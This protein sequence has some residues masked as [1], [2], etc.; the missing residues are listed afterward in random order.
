MLF[1]SA[2]PSS[3]LLVTAELK[4]EDA[5]ALAISEAQASASC[6][7]KAASGPP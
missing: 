5:G 6:R 7:L 4:I 1:E 2:S 3:G